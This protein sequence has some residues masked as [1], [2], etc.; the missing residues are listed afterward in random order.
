MTTETSVSIA[1]GA[2]SVNVDLAQL[3]SYII[4]NTVTTGTNPGVTVGR[5]VMALGDP[6][7]ALNIASIQA[8]PSTGA[9]Y[10]QIARLSPNNQDLIALN[11][12]MQNVLVEIRN[13]VS[14]LGGFP[15]SEAPILPS[16]Q[17]QQ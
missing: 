8:M 12:T 6:S 9:E 11:Q 16:Y 10:A 17:S 15:V 14:L 3:V 2:A 1:S 13:L 4:A 7:N 5:Q